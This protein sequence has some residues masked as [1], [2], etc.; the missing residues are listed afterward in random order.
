MYMNPTGQATL[1]AL[2]CI[3]CWTLERPWS[4]LKVPIVDPATVYADEVRWCGCCFCFLTTTKA[5]KGLRGK[6]LPLGDT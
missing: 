4:L 6:H 2:R 3:A 5:E 1:P